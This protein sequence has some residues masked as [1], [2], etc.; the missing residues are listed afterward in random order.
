VKQL[1]VVDRVGVK[2]EVPLSRF[3]DRIP[4]TL[5]RA[6]LGRYRAGGRGPVWFQKRCRPVCV[7]GG[8]AYIA[9]HVEVV[10]VMVSCAC[11]LSVSP[12]FSP[13]RVF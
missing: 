2:A 3:Q 12:G 5:R 4:P 1:W 8:C 7:A 9:A 6:A 10:D 13:A 11:S